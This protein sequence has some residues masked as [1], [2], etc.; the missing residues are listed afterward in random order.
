MYFEESIEI[1]VD[2]GETLDEDAVKE[3]LREREIEFSRFESV[4][5]GD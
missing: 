5:K 1:L 4:S 2:K 3:L